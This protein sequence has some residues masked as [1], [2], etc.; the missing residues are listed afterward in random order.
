M[1]N[2]AVSKEI[3]MN[4]ARK[5]DNYK[6]TNAKKA[7]DDRIQTNQGSHIQAKI[8]YRCSCVY[9]NLLNEF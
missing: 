1:E 4:I 2:F 9:Y 3:T 6:S 5:L 8:Q 7:R